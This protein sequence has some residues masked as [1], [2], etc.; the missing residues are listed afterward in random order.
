LLDANN[1]VV[2]E[3]F[4]STI[5]VSLLRDSFPS[6]WQFDPQCRNCLRFNVWRSNDSLAER[7]R[8]WLASGDALAFVAPRLQRYIKIG[9]EIEKSAC[10]LSIPLDIFVLKHRT[11]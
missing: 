11:L 9:A 3:Q 10:E 8:E 2:S 4:P 5:A 1:E 6:F 7:R